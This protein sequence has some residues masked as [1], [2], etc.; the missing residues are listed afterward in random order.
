MVKLCRLVDLFERW[1]VKLCPRVKKPHGLLLLSCGGLG[2]TVLLSHVIERFCKYADNKEPITILLRKDGSKTAF[3]FPDYVNIFIVDFPLFHKNLIYRFN[4]SVQLYEAN[5][6]A[7]IST[8]FLRHPDLDE[9]MMLASGAAETIAMQARP[10]TKYQAQL[11]KNAKTFSRLFDSGSVVQNKVLRW[12]KFANWLTGE[13][14]KPQLKLARPSNQQKA[15]PPLVLIQPFSAV[16]A[17]QCAPAVYEALF[18]TLPQ[19]T[20]I[21]ITGEPHEMDKNPTFAYLL[22]R[23]NVSFEDAGFIDLAGLVKTARLVVSVDTAVM[24][25][26]VAEGAPTLCLASAAYVGE[27]VPYAKDISPKNVEF[28]YKTMP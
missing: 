24:H 13:S 20:D 5:Y 7:V 10:W 21:R 11:D 12:F 18:D 22:N 17:K 25:L 14:I 1:R 8:D 26:S 15:E 19:D 4:I 3:L 23:P 28:Y 6:R 2:D 9:A 27:I 16:K